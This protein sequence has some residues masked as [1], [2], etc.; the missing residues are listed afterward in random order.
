[1]NL[2]SPFYYKDIFLISDTEKEG[3]RS[4]LIDVTHNAGTKTFGGYLVKKVIMLF[5]CVSLY[6]GVLS[7]QESFSIGI[8]AQL[9]NYSTNLA[10]LGVAAA[11]DFR[12]NEL[13][14]LGTS[15]VYSF[16][17]GN[18]EK[19][20]TNDPLTIMELSVNFRWYFLRFKSLVDWFFLWQN[21]LHF[22]IQPEIGF[23]ILNVGERHMA[24]NWNNLPFMVGLVF[25]V[26]IMLENVY[27]EPFIKGGQPYMWA[28]GF[29]VGMR[30]TG[31]E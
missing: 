31:R 9:N 17:L 29:L 28:G 3:V 10:G 27:I 16:D 5:F 19:T 25:G 24:S 30:V 13:I 8:G 15:F 2:Y 11:T 23:S 14:S 26:R 20:V 18:M 7:A 21:Y 4:G 12:F 6:T 1:M 22:Y